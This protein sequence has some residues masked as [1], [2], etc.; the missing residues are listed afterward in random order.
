MNHYLSLIVLSLCIA[1]VF[2]L[3]TKDTPEERIRYFL[4]LLAYMILGSL[5]TGWVMVF[6]AC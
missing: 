5:A 1:S 6:I 4:S 2:T 3:I